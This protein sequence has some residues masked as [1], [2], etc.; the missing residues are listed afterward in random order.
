[1]EQADQQRARMRWACRRGML[2]LDVIL[3]PYFDQCF[4][5]LSAA[6]K[7]QF[8]RLMTQADPDLFAWLMGH[9]TCSDPELAAQISAIRAFN[10]QQVNS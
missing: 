4:D 1:M 5:R 6:E 8:E 7:A 10:Q 3:L 9:Q 2:E